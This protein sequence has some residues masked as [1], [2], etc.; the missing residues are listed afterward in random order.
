MSSESRT[1]GDAGKTGAVP[2][3]ER[4]PGTGRTCV[5]HWPLA[6]CS[7]RRRH[8]PRGARRCEAAVL[9]R[10]EVAAAPGWATSTGLS[11]CL[12]RLWP[13]GSRLAYRRPTGSAGRRPPA[14][15]DERD[16]VS[17]RLERLQIALGS[18]LLGPLGVTVSASGRS[19]RSCATTSD[20]KSRPRVNRRCK[21]GEAGRGSQYRTVSHWA[22]AGHCL[23]T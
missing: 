17:H 15:Q 6:P 21:N 16:A 11:A 12:R 18:V 8:R 23:A 9:S 14:A 1:S 19:S 10:R 5:P 2:A 22:R 20:S 3:C 7:P 4:S 13:R